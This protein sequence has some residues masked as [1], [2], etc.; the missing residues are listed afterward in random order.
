MQLAIA[1]GRPSLQF[2]GII[3]FADIL[4]AQGETAAAA[5]LLAFLAGHAEAGAP[6]RDLA[7]ERLA[8]LPGGAG[9]RP[10]AAMALG[11]LANRIVAERDVG[12]RPLVAALADT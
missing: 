5:R 8:S 11:E 1:I 9:D 7:R 6:E 4:R 10:P 3:A 2:E 12:H